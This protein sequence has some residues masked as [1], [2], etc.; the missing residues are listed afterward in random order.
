MKLLSFVAAIVLA[1]GA[2]SAMAATT[3]SI[4]V[5]AAPTTVDQVTNATRATRPPRNPPVRPPRR[6]PSRI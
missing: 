4:V 1:A 6:P 2:H 3:G 5:S